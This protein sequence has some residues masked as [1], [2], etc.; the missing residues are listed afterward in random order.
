MFENLALKL[1]EMPA[2]QGM[3]LSMVLAQAKNYLQKADEEKYVEKIKP[4]LAPAVP[5]LSFV[6]TAATLALQGHAQEIPVDSLRP[7]LDVWFAALIT[8]IMGKDVKQ[9]VQNAKRK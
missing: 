5:V 3:I 7:F 2:V 6:V 8:H 1:L 4:F 9:V